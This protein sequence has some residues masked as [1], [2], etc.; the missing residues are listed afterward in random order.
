MNTR[1][2]LACIALG[3]VGAY[4]QDLGSLAGIAE[5]KDAASKRISTWDPTGG[6][7]D[8]IRVGAGETKTLAEIA[9]SGAI[10]HLWFTINSTSRY[11]L[12]E[13]VL[14]MYWDGEINPSVESPIGD[15]FGTGFGQY[16]SWWSL[17]LTVQDRALNCYFPMPFSRG[18]R[19]TIT[20]DGAVDSPNF[21]YHVDYEQYP[22]ASRTDSL[23]RFHAL[24]RRENP[25]AAVPPEIAKDGNKTG[26]E[27]FVFV[28]AVGRGQFVGVI[29]NVQ[30]F[31]T[32]WWGE[33]DDM[34]FVDGEPYPPSVHGTGLED[35]FNNAW[36]YQ[37]EFNYPFIGYSRKG[38]KDWTGMHTMYRFH[39]LDPIYFR[40][41][42][43]AGI[44]HGHA[45][46]RSDDYSSVAFWYQ[47]EPHKPFE[48]LL[49]VKQRYPNSMWRIEPLERM[50]PN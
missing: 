36:S 6:N 43:K 18:A 14:R 44:E 15:F 21:Y 32:G 24:W 37:E 17:P 41:S 27:N 23:G 16:K 3:C 39:I 28:D 50:L 40:K 11:H 13:L 5:L 4:P 22:G 35:Y 9:G 19:L 34:F 46:R 45:N 2:V 20:N 47:T 33:G 12:R 42:L 38:N 49:P 31:A 10:K 1:V 48:P 29:L 7:R 25:T 26:A 8:Y 30:G